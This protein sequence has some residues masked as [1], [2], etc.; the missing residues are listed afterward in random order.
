M[1]RKQNPAMLL[2]PGSMAITTEEEPPKI[3][4]DHIIKLFTPSET[5]TDQVILTMFLST[6]KPIF[7]NV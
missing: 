7:K 3:R 2:M 5:T 4:P 1:L 6:I